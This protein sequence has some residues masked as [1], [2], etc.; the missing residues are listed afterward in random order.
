[1]KKEEL[2]QILTG[3]ENP[4]FVTERENV[5]IDKCLSLI[6]NLEKQLYHV[7]FTPE[8]AETPWDDIEVSPV[9]Y[10]DE[11]VKGRQ[12]VE[13]CEEHEADFWSVYLHQVEGGVMCVADLPSKE[14]AE[15]LARLIH[16]TSANKVNTK[17]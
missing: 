8:S 12:C 5:I 2:L 6:N 7:D 3:V 4:Q 11:H 15:A 16:N 1:M 17:F 14:Q 10:V 9:Q 13:V